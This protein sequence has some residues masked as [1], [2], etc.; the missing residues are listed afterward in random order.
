MIRWPGRDFGKFANTAWIVE[1]GL[2]IIYVSLSRQ[3]WAFAENSPPMSSRR[4]TRAST[5]L[6]TT[7]TLCI[8]SLTV[9]PT[10]CACSAAALSK[11]VA[12]SIE[13]PANR[14]SSHQC[15]VRGGCRC[16]K[17]CHQPQN[18]GDCECGNHGPENPFLPAER[19]QRIA[20]DIKPSFAAFCAVSTM[21]HGQSRRD[22]VPGS[23][24]ATLNESR[25]T[26]ILLCTW[27][28]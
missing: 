19:S 11:T 20:D 9:I 15:C 14:S 27:Q 21:L 4:I 5:T 1:S 8:Q 16:G 3:P 28:T 24:P 23:P 17:A 7:V 18:G 25:S 6:V 13:T 10:A 22:A 12:V 2:W 26:Q